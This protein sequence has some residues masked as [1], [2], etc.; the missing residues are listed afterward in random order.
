MA[1]PGVQLAQVNVALPR[2]PLDSP[3]MAA[4]VRVLDDV[5]WL[6]DTSPGF[7][8]RRRPE[9]GPVILAPIEGDEV[10]VT[11]S[12][13]TD[14]E[15]LQRYVYRTAHGLF[16]RRG[17]ANWFSPLSGFTTAMWWVDEG[18]QPEVDEGLDRLRH[19]RRQGPTPTAFSLRRQFDPS[20]SGRG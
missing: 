15:S 20:P 10:I 17:R 7:V 19:L 4:F 11:L 2:A 18:D 5:N 13:W 14:F 16:M 12:T 9:H 3:A 8:W 6:A 1:Q